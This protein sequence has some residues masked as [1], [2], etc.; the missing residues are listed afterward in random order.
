MIQEI[1]GPELYSCLQSSIFSLVFQGRG[2][3]VS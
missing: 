2:T 1:N 3:N